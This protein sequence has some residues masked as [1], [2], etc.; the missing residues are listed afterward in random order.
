[1]EQTTK[2]LALTEKAAQKARHFLEKENKKAV[3]F[4]VS[5][6]GCSGFKYDI[7]LE[8]EPKQ[9]DVETE[10]KGIKLY[11]GKEGHDFLKGSEVDYYQTLQDSGFKVN[12][13]NVKRECG[14][15]ISV[16]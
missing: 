5:K 3:R 6:G 4:D 2:L 12:N 14:C 7:T 1:M 8:N 16:G 11:I 9:G 15:G 10:D 13:P